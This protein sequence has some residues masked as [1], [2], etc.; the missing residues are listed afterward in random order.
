[1][2]N[3]W[4]LSLLFC[5]VPAGSMAGNPQVNRAMIRAAEENMDQKLSTLWADNPAQVLGLTQGAYISGY[6]MVFMSE[7]NLSAG[8]PISPF[9][10]NITADEVKRIHDRKVER[11][12]KLKEAMQ[13]ML[14]DSAKSM[15]PVPADEQI[16]L[17]VSFFYW[18][19]ENKTGLPAQ[20]VMHAPRKLLLDAKTGAAAKSSILA[21][22]F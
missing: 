22:E 11:L 1:M 19:W 18:N 3:L 14:V 7:M 21:D 6:G 5:A 2:R 17:A 15:D 12:G 10:P 9:H 8:T 13:Q 4:A 20:I 16:A